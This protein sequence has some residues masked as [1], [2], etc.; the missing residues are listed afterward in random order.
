[1]TAKPE[2]CPECG[3]GQVVPIR[4]G[5]PTR[6]TE[7]AA[8]RGEV[9]LGGCF[10]GRPGGDPAWRCRSCRHEFGR[11]EGWNDDV[12]E[13]KMQMTI[14]VKI[15][16]G[17]HVLNAQMHALPRKGEHISCCFPASVGEE[18]LFFVVK[19]VFH[20]Q[21]GQ[22]FEGRIDPEPFMHVVTVEDDPDPELQKINR[23]VF[24]R[25]MRGAGKDE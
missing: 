1:M 4:Y 24:E 13:R 22:K 17:G 20:H 3:S 18:R 9:E 11:I 19:D 23:A 10:V 8:D 25:A 5:M 15:E 16:F 21:M 12:P 2:P 7:A 6:E 14:P